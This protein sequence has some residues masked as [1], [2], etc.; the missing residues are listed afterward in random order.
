MSRTPHWWPSSTAC[1]RWTSEAGR[2]ARLVGVTVAIEARDLSRFFRGERAL[3][4]LT[5]AVRDCLTAGGAADRIALCGGGARSSLWC[6]AIADATGCAVT[7][8]DTPEVGARGAALLGAVATGMAASL[9]DAVAAAVSPGAAY[10][11]N[12]A[13]TERF[14]SLFD[15]F[16][17]HQP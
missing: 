8:P 13:E 6:Q 17:A 14:D 7:A 4:G 11:P 15:R 16:R 9:A 5:L 3:D 1:T 10:P 12:P 2:A